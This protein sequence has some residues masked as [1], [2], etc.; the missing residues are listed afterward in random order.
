MPIANFFSSMAERFKQ[1]PFG[2]ARE[3]TDEPNLYN[4]GTS[5]Y[6]PID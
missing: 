2:A 6:H 1:G 4:G 5:G 3:S